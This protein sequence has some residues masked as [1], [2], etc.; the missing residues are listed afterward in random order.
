[1]AAKANAITTIPVRAEIDIL[2]FM[3][4]TCRG[5]RLGVLIRI[6]YVLEKFNI[7]WRELRRPRCRWWGVTIDKGYSACCNPKCIDL[8]KYANT[9]PQLTFETSY[10]LAS[11]TSPA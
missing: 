11:P 7:W 3:F 4:F 10:S 9:A 2:V 6:T 5:L 8:Q 1:M